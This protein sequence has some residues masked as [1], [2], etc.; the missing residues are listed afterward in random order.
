[1]IYFFDSLGNIECAILV[2]AYERELTTGE[3]ISNCVKNAKAMGIK[4]LI[5]VLNIK[6]K[7]L[8]GR[9]VY[10]RFKSRVSE[11]IVGNGY[12]LEAIACVPMVDCKEVNKMFEKL[13]NELVS[14]YSNP[15]NYFD[16]FLVVYRMDY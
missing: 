1:L 3:S 6:D 16:W 7:S 13:S 4:Q 15:N 5:V 10:D 12:E 8:M 2:V 9:E 11:K 14:I